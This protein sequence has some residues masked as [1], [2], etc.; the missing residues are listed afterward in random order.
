MYIFKRF[1]QFILFTLFTMTNIR[2]VVFYRFNSFQENLKFFMFQY[3]LKF[4]CIVKKN[5]LK[6]NEEEDFL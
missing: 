2:A 5:I 1:T 3:Y 4:S 6:R